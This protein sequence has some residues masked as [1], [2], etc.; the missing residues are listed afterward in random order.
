LYRIARHDNHRRQNSYCNRVRG[1]NEHFIGQSQA[2]A[3]ILGKI[4]AAASRVSPV[5]TIGKTGSDNKTLTKMEERPMESN[6]HLQ[7]GVPYV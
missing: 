6:L 3:T 4:S 7:K 1:D 2:L 5:I